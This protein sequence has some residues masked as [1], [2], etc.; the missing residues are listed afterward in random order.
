MD[1]IVTM[2]LRQVTGRLVNRGIDAGVSRMTRGR[3]REATPDQQ[4][5][6]RQMAGRVKQALRLARRIGR[7]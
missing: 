1:R 6:A 4:A 5:T 7:F 2:I 3:G